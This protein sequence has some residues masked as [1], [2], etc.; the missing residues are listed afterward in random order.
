MKTGKLKTAKLAFLVSLAL[1]VAAQ[2]QETPKGDAKNGE[3]LFKR[4]G[5][6]QCHG[7]QGA[8]ASTGPAIGQKPTA[9]PWVVFSN[10]VR[11]PVDQMPPYSSKVVSDQELAD[12]FAYT[13][14]FPGPVT[15]ADAKGLLDR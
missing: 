9:I 13:L 14:T 12:I 7:T 6:Y 8:G 3:M 4:N 10:E 5:C 1:T 15:K 11:N 2:A